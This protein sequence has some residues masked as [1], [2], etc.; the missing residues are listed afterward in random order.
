MPMAISRYGLSVLKPKL[1]TPSVV[2]VHF[3][4]TIQPS[5]LALSFATRHARAMKL[6]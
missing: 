4:Q 1:E 5:S 3:A 6:A 2:W